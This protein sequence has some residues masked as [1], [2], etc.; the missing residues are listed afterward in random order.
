MTNCNICYTKKGLGL[1]L[2]VIG[3]YI[4]RSLYIVYDLNLT[5]FP[6]ISHGDIC[7]DVKFLFCLKDFW[8]VSYNV[9]GKY[10]RIFPIGSLVSR[11]NFEI[12]LLASLKIL[13]LSICRGT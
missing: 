2:V 13:L 1:G 6:K 8:R 7:S 3:S 4:I 10:F 5:P 9:W 12:L 11:F